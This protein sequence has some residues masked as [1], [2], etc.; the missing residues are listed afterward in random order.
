MNQLTK[1]GL[2]IFRRSFASDSASAIPEKLN[3]NL[4]APSGSIYAD[5]Q[6]DMVVIPGLVGEYGVT[7]GHSPIMAQMK[8]GVI[9][10]HLEREKNVEKYFTAGGFAF[11]HADSTTDIAC[12]ELAKLED[13]DVAVAKSGLESSKQKLSAATAGSVEATD[14]RIELDVYQAMVNATGSD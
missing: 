9:S 12:V 5:K 10:V 13:L 4:S 7:A 8:P 3:L 2:G 1:R 6:V 14:A 11:T